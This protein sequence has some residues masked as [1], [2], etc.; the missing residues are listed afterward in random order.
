MPF[1]PNLDAPVNH[2]Y[3]GDLHTAAAKIPEADLRAFLAY[4]DALT[5]RLAPKRRP[6]DRGEP[7][8]SP[9]E[10]RALA[11]IDK[12]GEMPMSELARFLGV[13]LSTATHTVDKLVEKGLVE[14]KRAHPDRRVVL[15]GFSK[16][17]LRINRYVAEARKREGRAL[18]ATLGPRARRELIARLGRMSEAIAAA[19]D[20]SARLRRL[21]GRVHFSLSAAALKADR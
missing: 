16:R 19:S 15:V 3:L 2:V 5:E 1:Q 14:R 8:C 21:R 10:L 4:M 7:D 12:H 11:A 13:R 9:Q 20:P 6:Q 18:L 17:G